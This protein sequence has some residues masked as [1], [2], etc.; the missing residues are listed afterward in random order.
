MHQGQYLEELED[1]LIQVDLTYKDEMKGEQ[2]FFPIYERDIPQLF[3]DFHLKVSD[4]R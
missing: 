2:K 1:H 4:Q 3:H